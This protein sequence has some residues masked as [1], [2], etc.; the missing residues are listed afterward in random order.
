M[1]SHEAL[2]ELRPCHGMSGKSWGEVGAVSP[3]EMLLCP[4][5]SKMGILDLLVIANGKLLN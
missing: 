5:C 2:G 1:L 4:G 3:G